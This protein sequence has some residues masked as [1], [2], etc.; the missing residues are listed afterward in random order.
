MRLHRPGDLTDA[1]LASEL[2]WMAALVAAGTKLPQPVPALDGEFWVK[3]DGTVIDVLAW[4]D[5]E[6]FG[7][8]G[9]LCARGDHTAIAAELGRS[10][11]GIHRHS[12]AWTPPRDFVRPCWDE[13]GLLGEAPLWGRFWE[14][15]A[16]SPDEADLMSRV[17]SLVRAELVEIAPELDYGLIHADAVPE[18][19]LVGENAVN[20]IDFDDGGYGY[21]LF[22]LAT[23][24]NY[25]DKYSPNGRLSESFLDAYIETRSI[26]QRPLPLFQLLRSLTYVGWITPRMNE[27]VAG[28]YYQKYVPDAV[29]RAVQ[30]LEGDGGRRTTEIKPA[31]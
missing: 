2:M 14:N 22:D 11:A 4:L 5:A 19:V 7:K 21:R 12:D 6:P 25:L 8:D 23:T 24:M 31:S 1:E 16:L 27:G 15:P 20:I 28:D 29:Q 10:L 17:R 30:Y 9:K 26:D 18:N 13:E 3:L